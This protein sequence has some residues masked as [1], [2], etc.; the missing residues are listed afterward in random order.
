MAHQYTAIAFT[1][2]VKRVQ[3]EQ[4]SRANYAAMAEGEDYNGLLSQQETQFIANRDSFYMASV[5]ETGWPYVQHRG[6]PTGLLRVLDE[7]TLGFA[8]F[9][10]NRQYISTGNFRNNDR[11]ALFLMDYP[12]RTRLKIFGRISVI[13]PQDLQALARLEDD[14]YRARIERGFLINIEGFDWN[15]PQHITPRYSEREIES[16]LAP[17]QAENATLTEA[18]RQLAERT[19]S[20]GQH[21]NAYQTLGEGPLELII[22][23]IRQLTPRIRA[24]EFRHPDNQPLPLITAGSH[25]TLPVRIDNGELQQRHYSICSNPARRDIYE[26]AILNASVSNI[27]HADEPTTSG[28]HWIH[29]HYQLG[30]KVRCAQPENYFPL[31]PEHERVDNSHDQA[32]SDQNPAVLLAGGIGITPIKAMAQTLQARGIRFDLYYAGRTLQDM[33][34]SDRLEREFGGQLHL[35]SSAERQRMDVA[36]II[37]QAPA[38]TVFYACGPQRLLDNIIAE[39][40][41][42]GIAKARVR[43]ERFIAPTTTNDQPLT[44]RL[45]NAPQQIAVAAEQSIL[46]ALLDAGVD[47]NYGCK[48]GHCKSCAVEV[49]EGHVEHRDQ[50]LSRDEQTTHKMMCPCVSRATGE[51][52]TLNI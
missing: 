31:H 35:Y 46:D 38:G 25:L 12:N 7:K 15:C 43:F 44:V 27:D 21:S 11:V 13:D 2:Q 48:T 41:R 4:G 33:A 6:G 1:D 20:G 14:S 8:D 17:L 34:F 5:S 50:I 22:S 45:K 49:I 36:A 52:L 19:S 30:M 24:F 37:S 9:S 26:V 39:T 51:W 47:I 10:G 23:G 16:L 3:Q 28:A 42:Q 40:E 32:H 29:H 18:N